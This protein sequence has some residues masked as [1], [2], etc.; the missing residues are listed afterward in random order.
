MNEQMGVTK[1]EAI[2]LPHFFKLIIFFKKSAFFLAFMFGVAGLVIFD[3]NRPAAIFWPIGVMIVYAFFIFSSKRSRFHA[4]T[5]GDNFY[6]LGFLF[7][8]ASLS[9]ALYSFSKHDGDVYEIISNFGIA[10]TT[11]IFGLALRIVFC[12]LKQDPVETEQEAR[13]ELSEAALRLKNEL[14]NSVNQMISFQ[15]NTQQAITIVM[16]ELVDRFKNHLLTISDTIGNTAQNVVNNMDLVSNS[17]TTHTE[18]L[19]KTAGGIVN[20]METLIHRIHAVEV[21]KNMIEKKLEPVFAVINQAMESFKN[22][23]KEDQKQLKRFSQI[24]ETVCAATQQLDGRIN[25]AADQIQSIDFV[26]NRIK[27]MG[28][29][30][31]DI[32]NETRAAANSIAD[33]SN[34]YNALLTRMR[35]SAEINAREATQTFIRT[36]ERQGNSISILM[37]KAIENSGIVLHQ[38][39]TKAREQIQVFKGLVAAAESNLGVLR[40]NNQALENQLKQTRLITEEILK[41]ASTIPQNL[42]EK[43]LTDRIR[44]NFRRPGG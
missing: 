33:S 43:Y 8:L 35:A 15:E 14:D 7:T 16:G 41:A 31:N 36:L 37:N 38:T 34:Q 6:Y 22:R 11:T 28:D 42:R 23:A 27:A 3:G 9:Y 40:R 20:E 26:I 5:I 12:Q 32:R 4:D 19:N 18:K 13:I 17:F 2:F 10:L 29:G 24:V 25:V 21:P 1:T 30:L 44:T 39:Q